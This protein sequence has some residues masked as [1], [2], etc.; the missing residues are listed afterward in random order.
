MF[1]AAFLF[2]VPTVRIKD[3]AS[4]NGIR[5]NQLSGI[6]LVTGLAGRGDSSGSPLLR[7]TLSNLLSN[8]NIEVSPD[9]LKSK[10]C[11]V[12]MVTVELPPFVRPGDRVNVTVSSIGDARTLEGGILLQT[13]LKAANNRVY[14]V[15]QGRVLVP[16]TGQVVETV[17]TITGGGIVEREITSVY[18]ENGKIRIILRNPDF[19]TASKVAEAITG[20]FDNIQ[21]ESRDAAMIEVTIP[22]SRR[23]N[24][25]A[26]IAEIEALTLV[27]DISGKV[28]IDPNSGV[29]IIGENVKVGKVA[30]SYRD[31]NITVGSYYGQQ[32]ESGDKFVIEDT[33]TV[34]DLVDVLRTAGLSTD[35]I[36]G[37]LQAIERSGALF[38]T[39]IVM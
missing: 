14:A 39:L 8:F 35:I 32:E 1:C 28:V 15:A 20:A 23:G 27:P 9:D 3:I 13:N 33:T 18:N 29:I 22:E 26:F 4:L 2:S 16:K 30:V 6:G 38:G 11:A 17:G 31:I 21:V 7:Q 36:I 5:D 25:V 19:V 10:N 37:I 12:V 34:N 24:P